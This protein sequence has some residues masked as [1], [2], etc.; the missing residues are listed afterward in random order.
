MLLRSPPRRL[1]LLL[2][3]AV[4]DK[5]DVRK[6]GTRGFVRRTGR[7]PIVVAFAAGC[8][9]RG[10]REMEGNEGVLFVLA[11]LGAE[12]GMVAAL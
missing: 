12:A 1:P 6:M 9:L 10:S 4:L 11:V 3:D 8:I 2:E 7:A 5:D